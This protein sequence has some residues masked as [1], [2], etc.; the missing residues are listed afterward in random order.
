MRHA[1]PGPLGVSRWLAPFLL[2]FLASSFEIYLLREFGAQFYGN[3]LIFGLFLGSWLLWG[4]IG[5]LIKPRAA[6]QDVS[7]RLAGLYAAA[8]LLFFAGLAALRF[9]HRLLGVLPAELT[10]LF[11]A[12]GFAL[13]LSLLV[14]LPLGHSFGLNASRHPGGVAAV[15]VL[16]SAG[17]AAAGLAVHFVLIPHLTNW[18]GAALVGIVAVL[19]VWITMTPGRARA[20]LA[21]A[22]VLGAGAAVLDLPSQK[23]SWKPLRLVDGWD[24]LYGK[25]QVIRTGDQVTFFDNGLAVFSHPDEGAAEEAVHFALLQR[26]GPRRVLL[27]GGGVGGGAAEALKYPGLRVDCVEIDPAVVRAAKAHLDGPDRAA[28]DDP[29]V[30]LINRDGRTF[31]A[32][33]SEAFDAILLSL[34]EPATAQVNRYYTREFFEEARAKLRPGGILSF[35]VPSAENYISAPLGEFLGSLAATLRGV[36]VNV[37]AVPGENCVFLASDGPLTLDP[38]VLSASIERLGLQLRFVS[39][40]MLPSRL[41]PARVEYLARKLAAPGARINRDLVPVSYYFHAV[42]WAGQFRGVESRLLRAASRLSPGWIL[43]LPLGIFGVVLAVLVLVRKRS[44]ASA[45]VPV[46]VMGFTSIAVELAVFI[47]FQARF[48]FVYGKIPLLVALF[49][50]GLALG[51]IAA[52][53]RKRPGASEIKAV[54]AAF[55]VLLGLTFLVLPSAGRE[56]DIMAVLAAFGLLGGYLFVAANRLLLPR[57][58]HPGLA[59]GI[60]LLASFAGVILASGLVIPLFGIPALVMRLIVLNALCLVYLLALPRLA[61]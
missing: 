38:S 15:Y 51:A 45:L 52:R 55:V 5:S 16:E 30:T 49:M 40:G 29:R 59:Y 11:P 53:S 41:D 33:T 26:D 54:Q 12:L 7:K 48:G 8:A 36:F 39:P 56:A 50:A 20:I 2:G 31:I 34:P 42:L 21:A 43:D 1:D 4:G 32:E 23:A 44:A 18:Q 47:A 9:S 19:L 57:T 58:A 14:N 37:A 17:A 35:V 22:M 13:L 46:A 24:T 60:D 27:I 10:G 28:L 61:S 3:E 6:P 25:L